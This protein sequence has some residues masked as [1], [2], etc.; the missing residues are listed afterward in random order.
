MTKKGGKPKATG[1]RRRQTSGS[2]ASSIRLQAEGMRAI[3]RR[4]LNQNARISVI[5]TRLG[6]VDDE[7]L[8]DAGEGKA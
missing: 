1:G 8:D 7:I 6:I 3:R 4:L 5:E 2:S